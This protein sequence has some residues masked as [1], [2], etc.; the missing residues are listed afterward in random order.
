MVWA[1]QSGSGVAAGRCA[2]A[3]QFRRSDVPSAGEPGT[4]PVTSTG[5]AA[6]VNGSAGNATGGANAAPGSAG[7]ASKGSQPL[8]SILA[9]GS[10]SVRADAVS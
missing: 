4:D 10:G 1:R 6:G 9:G 2:Y 8:A 7:T 3:D 5:G